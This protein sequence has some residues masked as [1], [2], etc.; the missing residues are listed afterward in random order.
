MGGR[1][2]R[3]PDRLCYEGILIRLVTGCSWV[4]AEHFLGGAVSDTTLRVPGLVR[5]WILTREMPYPGP[6]GW[7]L[8]TGGY[9]T[10]AL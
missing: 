2:R 8:G 3:I 10:T 5:Y 4:T 7:S 1:R 9:P 6:Y